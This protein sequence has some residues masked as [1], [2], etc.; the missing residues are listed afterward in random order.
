MTPQIHVTVWHAG[1]VEDPKW[2]A[3]T[4]SAV[5]TG[6]VEEATACSSRGGETG[7]YQ[8]FQCLWAPP[9]DDD[10]LLI[11]GTGDLGGGRR[12]DG[13]GKELVTGEGGM[14]DDG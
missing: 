4:H 2:D 13:G 8:V 1:D 11:P 12:L 9:G 14:E 6:I 7:N 3:Q 5:Q 10:L